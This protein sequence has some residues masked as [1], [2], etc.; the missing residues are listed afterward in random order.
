MYKLKLKNNEY[1]EIQIERTEEQLRQAVI[2]DWHVK[3]DHP[4]FIAYCAT[5]SVEQNPDSIGR[6]YFTIQPDI[7]T[8]AHEAVH[9]ASGIMSR[10]NEHKELLFTAGNATPA[11]EV[12]CEWV[13]YITEVLSEAV[14]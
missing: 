4:E 3:E 12:F 10:Y 9:M 14:Q 2:K 7:N 6:V 13:G 11:E 8:I 1:I 5:Y